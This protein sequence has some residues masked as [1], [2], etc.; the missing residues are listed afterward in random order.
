VLDLH[1]LSRS[2]G[3][4]IIGPNTTDRLYSVG[5]GGDLNGDGLDDV[6]VS[7][8]LINS[9][10]GASFVIFGS[11]FN[12]YITHMGTSGDD[13]LTGTS[14]DDVIFGG[15]GADTINALGGNDVIDGGIGAN[16]ING[17]TGNDTMIYRAQSTSVNGGADTDTLWFKD[18]GV[19]ANLRSTS[20]FT[21]IDIIDLQGMRSLT[22]NT[23]QLDANGVTSMS[24]ANEIYINGGAQDTVALSLADV[25]L[26]STPHAG[27]VT[28]TAS[29]GAIV[30]V[31]NSITHPVQFI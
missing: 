23:V 2:E 3:F 26:S 13:I 4:T 22:G 7:G 15:A 27:Y 12:N 28:Y 10:A 24:D 20:V 14:G 30:N 19:L 25:W 8:Y 29:S 31:E 5:G 1:N 11:N 21:G 6:V 17:G 18:D 16:V 9:N